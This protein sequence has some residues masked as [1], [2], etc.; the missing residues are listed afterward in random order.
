M[1]TTVS[2][3]DLAQDDLDHLIH[4]LFH[5][6]AHENPTIFERGE[7][8][9]LFD[10]K[11]N[12]YIDGLS[13][14]WN[15]NVGHGRAELA[16]AGAE[17]MR[18]LAFVN[19]YTG[20]SNIPAIELATKLASLAP[21]DLNGV[22]FTSG[23][24][25]S[26]ESAFKMARFIWNVQGQ[27]EKYK[28]ISRMDAYHGV[29]LAA[30]G[31]TGIPQYW[32]RFGPPAPG[33]FHGLAP[34]IYRLGDGDPEKAAQLA[35]DSIEE[36]VAKEGAN[37]VAAV[38]AEPI[39]GAGGVIVP[40]PQYLR[41]LREL[42]DQHNMLLIAD[43]IIT[44]FGRTGR[45]FAQEHYGM[46]ADIMAFAKG[47]TSGYVQ[48]GGIIVSRRIQEVLEQQ[49]MDV[50]WMHAY[51]YSAHPTACAVGLANIAIIEREGLVSHAD[52]MGKYL[53]NKLDS[54]RALR[55]VGDVRGIGLLARVEL[56]KDTATKESFAPSD[57]VGDRVMAEA[58]KRGLISRNRG[59]V[60]CIA[61]PLV[62]NEAEIDQLVGILGDSIEAVTSTL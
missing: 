61:P 31:A 5:P 60:I 26:N 13:C 27:P 58:R 50:R 11:G 39:Q 49:P 56:V 1:T 2:I 55:H 3:E 10:V 30:L 15:V 54:L 43:E 59:E 7:G 47:V 12:R 34:N 33:F 8:V 51:T 24:G 36:I 29:T 20:F 40:P 48:L 45:W 4:P 14:L 17:Q 62:I 28:I 38:V 41:M 9:W 6:K 21:G 52:D 25:E 53:L 35:I 16:E 22:F 37:T 44:G 57:R 42:C 46:Q 32:D 18:T 19:S 23:G